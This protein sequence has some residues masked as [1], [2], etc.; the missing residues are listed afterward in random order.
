MF[1]NACSNPSF[2]DRLVAIPLM[3]RSATME[4]H[5]VRRT[6]EREKSVLEFVSFTGKMF[7]S[8][9]AVVDL[10]QDVD[11]I[12]G[13]RSGESNRYRKR[14]KQKRAIVDNLKPNRRAR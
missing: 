11:D 9:P 2:A 3:E 12:L 8:V 7:E 5:I 6:E 1:W 13:R 4:V 14:P 10:S